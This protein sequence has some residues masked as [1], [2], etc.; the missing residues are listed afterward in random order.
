MTL[1]RSVDVETP[2]PLG[3]FGSLQS[4]RAYPHELVILLR[5][6]PPGVKLELPVPFYA[7]L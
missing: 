5:G 6:C 3:C 7:L 2:S 1:C 4:T